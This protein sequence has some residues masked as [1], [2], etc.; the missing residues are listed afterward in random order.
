M[1]SITIVMYF[2]SADCGPPS[3][4]VNGSVGE[5]TS[6]RVGAQVTYSCDTHLVLVGETVANCSPSL[7][8]I[9]SSVDVNCHVDTLHIVL[10][11][12]SHICAAPSPST[13]RGIIYI[14]LLG[15]FCAASCCIIQRMVYKMTSDYL[16]SLISF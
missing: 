16:T 13:T 1:F 2:P 8:W 11:L 6:S 7:T 10:C 3:P 12:C 4:P 14:I 5:W 9:P 15:V